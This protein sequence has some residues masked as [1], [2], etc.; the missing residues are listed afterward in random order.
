MDFQKRDRLDNL[1]YKS[2]SMIEILID[3]VTNDVC[4]SSPDH[5]ST[6]LGVVRDNI[7]EIENILEEDRYEEPKEDES[8]D[9]ESESNELSVE[10]IENHDDGSATF[11]ING[12]DKTMKRVFEVF[13]KHALIKGMEVVEDE[14]EFDVKVLAVIKSAEELCKCLDR[15]MTED[16]FDYSPGCEKAKE[17][18]SKALADL[19]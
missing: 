9:D 7:E 6:V 15:F 18:L 2:K 12:S 5:V 10:H 8:E 13:F 19:K 1:T 3:G 16:E 14:N 17:D 4:P 11:L